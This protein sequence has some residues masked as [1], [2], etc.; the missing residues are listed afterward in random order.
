[1]E[2]AAAEDEVRLRPLQSSMN[3]LA[4]QLT[5]QAESIE[6]VTFE[7]QLCCRME[8]GTAKIIWVDALLVV[9]FHQSDDIL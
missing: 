9:Q 8:R 4:I 2:A 3:M 5:V 7:G 6:L 1:M